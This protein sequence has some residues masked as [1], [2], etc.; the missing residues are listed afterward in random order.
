MKES[1]FVIP[2]VYLQEKKR[3]KTTVC[4]KSRISNQLLMMQG[5]LS[6]ISLSPRRSIGHLPHECNSP[7]QRTRFSALPTYFNFVLVL[8]PFCSNRHLPPTVHESPEGMAS[9]ASFTLLSSD[10]FVERVPLYSITLSSCLA[11]LSPQI[12]FLR[13]RLTKV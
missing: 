1:E 3:Y 8:N 4:R 13:H 6:L 9:P 11:I 2:W 5:V 7:F 12:I 10:F